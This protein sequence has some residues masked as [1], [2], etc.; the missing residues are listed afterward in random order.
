MKP[1]SVNSKIW[2]AVVIVHLIGI[3]FISTSTVKEKPPQ[4][5][6]HIV[7]KHFTP[8]TV[9]PTLV[10]KIEKSS[11]LPPLP[12]KP[13]QNKIV[14]LKKAPPQAKAKPPQK[15]SKQ[16]LK[17][18]D[19]RLAKPHT[20]PPKAPPPHVVEIALPSYVDSACLIFRDAL[21]L[22]EKGQV[23]LTVSMESNG[24][25]GKMEIET[26]E[27]KKNLEYLM[28][29]LPT[30]SLPYPEKGKE[31]SFTVLFSND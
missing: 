19:Q 15:S 29:V 9:V 16:V 17:K 23:K 18:I 31:I 7:T 4:K 22:P 21:L 5:K 30:L 26:F 20:P 1:L 2:V 3:I 14:P 6:L 12:K 10:H 11:P 25:I 8:K 28:A 24:K 27:S 13:L